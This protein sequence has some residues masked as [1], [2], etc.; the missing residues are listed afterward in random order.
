MIK[1]FILAM[2][3]CLSFT[4]FA[5]DSTM[6]A[7][8]EVAIVKVY[9]GGQFFGSALNYSIFANGEKI[10]K[11]SN[12]KYIEFEVPV[13]SVEI[14]ALRGGVEVFKRKTGVMLETEAGGTYYIKCDVKSSITRT[15]LELS[16]VTKSTANRDMV[17]MERDNCQLADN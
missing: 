6:Q 17:D 12:N 5:Q 13:G 9:R 4:S 1:Q 11:L 2:A 16:E 8:S 15:R 3:I 10:C 7:N 14:N